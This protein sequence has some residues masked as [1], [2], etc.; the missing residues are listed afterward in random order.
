[1]RN[2]KE[3]EK[4]EIMFPV[5]P[6]CGSRHPGWTFAGKANSGKIMIRCQTCHHRITA[7]YG[8]LTYYSHQTREQW[9]TLIEDTEKMH[10]VDEMAESVGVSSMTIRRM[11]MKLKKQ[12]AHDLSID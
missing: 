1:M 12:K 4:Y 5:C 11:Q 9:N 2:Q 10:T 8:T 6:K 3:K 7:D